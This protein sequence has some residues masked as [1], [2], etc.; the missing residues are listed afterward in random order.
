MAKNDFFDHLRPPS[1]SAIRLDTLVGKLSITPITAALKTILTEVRSGIEIP[2]EAGHRRSV[3]QEIVLAPGDGRWWF[4]DQGRIY[5]RLVLRGNR[6]VPPQSPRFPKNPPTSVLQ[7]S[8]ESP[9][10]GMSETPDCK[11]GVTDPPPARRQRWLSMTLAGTKRFIT[12]IFRR[13]SWTKRIVARARVVQAYLVGF[14]AGTSDLMGRM[15]IRFV[16]FLRRW[17]SSGPAV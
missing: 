6:F 11:N 7:E 15:T 9:A 5:E 10:A 8:V 1:W 14:A 12:G 17:T 2:D 3:S 13:P 16:A 4:K